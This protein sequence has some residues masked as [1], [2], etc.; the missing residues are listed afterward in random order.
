M[1][2]AALRCDPGSRFIDMERNRK[3]YKD[4]LKLVIIRPKV[5]TFS[6]TW[7]NILAS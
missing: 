5:D 7:Y 6:C 4:E 2:G 1:D 3:C